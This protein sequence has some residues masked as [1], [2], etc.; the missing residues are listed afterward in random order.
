[1]CCLR[2]NSWQTC[3]VAPLRLAG[4]RRADLT[5]VVS[6][7]VIRSVALTTDGA[8]GRLQIEW[9]NYSAWVWNR[10]SAQCVKRNNP[11]TDLGCVLLRAHTQRRQYVDASLTRVV[12][13]IDASLTRIAHGIDA[14]T[15]PYR[16]WHRCPHSPVSDMAWTPTRSP[17]MSHRKRCS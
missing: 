8:S 9:S 16:T 14:L 3:N 12:H 2:N 1:M 5:L 7:D 13:G 15:H 11:A 4:C 17:N 10:S 6:V